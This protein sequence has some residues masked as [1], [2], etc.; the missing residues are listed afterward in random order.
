MEYTCELTIHKPRERVTE[1][2]DSPDNLSKW[3]PTLQSFEPISGE[4][5]Q[6]GAKSRLVYDENGRKVELIETITT[7]NLP[8]EFTGT[9]DAKGVHNVVINRFYEDRPDKTRWIVETE[10]KFS[11]LMSIVSQFMRGSFRKQ[12]LKLMENFKAY[13]ESQ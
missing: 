13:A 11:G 7:R 10:F 8:D 1:L 12:P 6:P 4:P 9:Y 2:F 5:G 3:Q